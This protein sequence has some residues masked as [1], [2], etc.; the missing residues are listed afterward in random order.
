MTIEVGEY[1]RSARTGNVYKILFPPSAGRFGKV[2][3]CTTG[4]DMELHILGLEEM[5]VIAKDDEEYRMYLMKVS[6]S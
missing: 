2:M 6:L 4:Y 5:P 3:D 1:R